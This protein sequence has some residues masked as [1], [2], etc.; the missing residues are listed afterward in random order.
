MSD[1]HCPWSEPYC[2]EE[3]QLWKDGKCV[4]ERIL[5]ALKNLDRYLDL[6]GPVNLARKGR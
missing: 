5:E 3:C 4:F 6:G 1:K 2:G